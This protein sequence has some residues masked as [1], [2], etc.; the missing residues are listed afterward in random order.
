M[1]ATWKRIHR[2]NAIWFSSVQS[3]SCV[4]LLVSNV[5]HLSF[6][7]KIILLSH[8][9]LP[10]CSFCLKKKKKTLLILTSRITLTM[11]AK[12]SP[13][14]LFQSTII[15]RAPPGIFLLL[16]GWVDTTFTQ[17]LSTFLVSTWGG[18]RKQVESVVNKIIDAAA[19]SCP[20]KLLFGL[21]VNAWR[22]SG[23]I[24]SATWFEA[25]SLFEL[26]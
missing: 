4:Q 18:K 13:V 10:T 19:S 14:A 9:M 3:L 6:Q 20:G 1:M 23:H 17:H 12:N 25:Y 2:E 21:K 5:E 7:F 15:L 8:S 26:L 11:P 22:W 16:H 24:S